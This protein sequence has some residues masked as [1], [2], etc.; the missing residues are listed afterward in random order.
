MTSAIVMK[1][2]TV[3]F[4]GVIANNKINFSIRSEREEWNSSIIIQEILKNIGFGGGH[5]D[6][7][8]GIINDIKLFNESEIYNKF[9]NLL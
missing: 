7:A 3:T 8:G 2:I 9:I 5:A 6:M 4:P 1:D